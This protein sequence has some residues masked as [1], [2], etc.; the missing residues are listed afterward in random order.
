MPTLSRGKNGRAVPI[1][2]IAYPV[3]AANL[4]GDTKRTHEVMAAWIND[5]H[6]QYSPGDGPGSAANV[7]FDEGQD[8]SHARDGI[9]SG[10]TDQ[11]S[12]IRIRGGNADGRGDRVP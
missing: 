9:P 11:S 12:S 10:A 5:L 7:D 6:G 3:R 1:C 8:R 4:F 2:E